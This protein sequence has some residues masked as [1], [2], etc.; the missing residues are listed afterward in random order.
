M[1]GPHLVANHLL[2]WVFGLRLVRRL[3]P[4]FQRPSTL[5]Q[6]CS[7]GTGLS[8]DQIGLLERHFQPGRPIFHRGHDL[9][10]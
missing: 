6:V 2:D 5:K 10:S 4:Q 7:L 1:Y 8:V 9:A 3:D